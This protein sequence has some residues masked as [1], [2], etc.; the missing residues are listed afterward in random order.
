MTRGGG[1]FVIVGVWVI[2]VVGVV[3]GLTT[4][5]NP[6]KATE[7]GLWTSSKAVFTVCGE[8]DYKKTCADSLST[9]ANNES[10][11]PMDFLQAAIN[12]AIQE[13]QA[14]M[15]L[16]DTIGKSANDP[17]QK[18][19]VEDCKDLLQ[20]A[21]AELQASFSMVGDSS[22]HTI[23]DREAELKNWLSAV[24]SYQQTCI[25]G[26]TTPELQ[27][28]I[29]DGLLN[30]TQLTDNALAIVTVISQ[31]F[32]AFNINIPS[33]SIL[34]ST[35][36]SSGRLLEEDHDHDDDGTSSSSSFPAWLP[37]GDRKLLA[38]K[39]GGGGQPA[40]NAVVA[41]DGSGGYK[42]ISAALAAYPKNHKGRYVIYVKA[43]VYDETVTITKDLVNVYMYGDG[44][45]KSIVTGKKCFT[46]GVSTF[47][48]APFIAIGDG[49]IAKSMGFRNTAGPEGHQA[50]ALRVQSDMSAFYNC[51]MDGYQDTLYAQT[52]RQFYRNCVISGTVDFIFGDS[53][54]VIQ[55]CLIIVRKPM[56]NQ[57]NTVTAQGRTQSKETT[58][59][60]IQNCRIVPE[61]KLEPLR[62]KIPTYLG[63]PWK[64]YSK[65]IIMESTLA[66]F[67]QPAGWMPW[68]GN[69]ALD[70]LY[71]REY[72]NKGPGA[73]TDKRVKWKGYSVITNRD[74]ALQFTAAPFIQADQ[75]LTTTGVP[76][77]LGLKN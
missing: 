3:I 31:I 73:P 26:F 48:T 6:E 42:T 7:E 69:F 28:A 15:S 29:S 20:Y 61:Q 23:S 16:P 67:I 68:S 72:A 47:Q 10:A 51:R 49:F 21:V 24:I 43:G 71:Y 55:N 63:R 57:Q 36:A 60:V 11:T 45:R 35:A 2:L 5:V 25:D 53:A 77:F 34:N 74:D 38:S 1:K 18:M 66:D 70:T 62:F 4:G 76:Y 14:A 33:N 17:Q 46:D 39:S 52:H 54:V 40:P 75:W 12:V 30:A 27:K 19:A 8:T 50:V 32:Q 56:D 65:T 64:K 9:V 59:I 41:Q 37:A 58:G 22:L 13:V 44:P